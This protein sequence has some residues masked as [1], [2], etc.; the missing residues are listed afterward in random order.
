MYNEREYQ[1]Y[2][3]CVDNSLYTHGSRSHYENMLR[4]VRENSID[5]TYEMTAYDIYFHSDIETR[6]SIAKLIRDIK[7]IYEWC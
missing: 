3:Y 7:Q 4:N 2:T 5:G 6:P 1:V